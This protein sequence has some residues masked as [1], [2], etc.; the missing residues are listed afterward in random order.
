MIL[1][2]LQAS[3]HTSKSG[4]FSHEMHNRITFG[5]GI[6]VGQDSGKLRKADIRLR[7]YRK[8]RS[9]RQR[10]TGGMAFDHALS[11]L[12]KQT[13]S[14]SIF[15]VKNSLKIA[16]LTNR[17]MQTQSLITASPLITNSRIF[18]Y[19]KSRHPKKPESS[20][21][22]QSTMSSADDDDRRLAALE[23]NLSST[24]LWPRAVLR[25][26]FTIEACA[27]REALQFV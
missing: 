23:R 27:L 13:K 20:R 5:A 24:P 19:H 15:L 6:Y 7:Y 26:I 14:V 18:L 12:K 10:H 22:I 8:A 16:T 3:S 2:N 25:F 4:K 21:N 1:A 11:I 17:V 9:T